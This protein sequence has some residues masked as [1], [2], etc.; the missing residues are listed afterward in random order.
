MADDVRPVEPERIHQFDDIARHA[1]HRVGDPRMV[2]LSDPAMVVHDYFEAFGEDRNLIAPIGCVTA[3]A[4][5]ENDGESSPMPLVVK[6]TIADRYAR[7]GGPDPIQPR[8]CSLAEA[9]L[10]CQTRRNEGRHAACASRQAAVI[11]AFA[12]RHAS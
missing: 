8:W 12:P 3:E 2:A 7:H 4:G 11:G 5:D 9:S 6:L 10:S 1:V